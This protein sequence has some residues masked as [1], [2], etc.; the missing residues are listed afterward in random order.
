MRREDSLGKTIMLGM[1]EENGQKKD[2]DQ[3]TRRGVF[4]I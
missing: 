1:M 3:V 4:K 2:Q